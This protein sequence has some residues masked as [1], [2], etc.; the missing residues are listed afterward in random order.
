M[1]KK[2]LW[3]YYCKH[4]PAFLRDDPPRLTRE[5]LKKF[6]NSTWEHGHQQGLAE[7]IK[8]GKAQARAAGRQNM[9]DLPEGFEDILGGFKK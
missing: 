8:M 4:N 1:N 2:A 6:F 7:G 5:G 9:P 3:Q